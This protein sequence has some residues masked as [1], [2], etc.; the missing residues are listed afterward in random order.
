MAPQANLAPFL[1]RSS[2]PLHP[3]PPPFHHHL[4]F[5]TPAIHPCHLTPLP[6]A[7]C[8]LAICHSSPLPRAT[9]AITLPAIAIHHPLHIG[10]AISHLPKP[11]LLLCVNTPAMTCHSTVPLCPIATA[12]SYTEWRAPHWRHETC[13]DGTMPAL[14]LCHRQS[15]RG[16]A[17]ARALHLRDSGPHPTAW[18]SPALPNTTGPRFFS[19]AQAHVAW[20]VQSV[21]AATIIPLQSATSPNSGMAHQALSK[22][23]GMGR[24][25]QQTA[26][27][28][29]STGSSQG[30]V[31][32]QSTQSNTGAP[33]VERW[34]MEPKDALVQRRSDPLTPYSVKAWAEQL[35]ELD[36]Q[37]KYPL[38]VQGLLHSF[39][40]GIPHIE[41]TYI[42]PNHP[43]FKSLLNVYTSII[44]NEF[45]AG[46]YIGPFTCNQLEQAMGSFQTSPLSLVP[47]TS[48]PG[49]YRAVQIFSHL[50]DPT[51]R[52]TSVNSH[53]DCNDFP[54]TWG[55]F[56]TVALLISCLPPGLQASVCNVVDAYRTIPAAP[57]QWPGLVIRLQADDQFAVN[58]CNNFGFASAGGVYGMLADA[59]ADVFWG[60]GMGPLTKWVDDHM[61]FCL[62]RAHLSSYNTQQVEWHCK[63]QMHGACRQEGS[64]L[65][66]GGKALPSGS[67]EE[68]DE[69]CSAELCDLSGSSPC[70]AAD[71]VFAYA[72]ADIDKLSTHLGI[73]WQASKSV[74]FRT[75]FPYLGFWWDLHAQIVHLPDEKK[76]SYLAAITEWGKKHMHNLLEAQK[77]YRKLLHM[78]LV[79]PAGC[80]HLT[81][82]DVMTLQGQTVARRVPAVICGTRGQG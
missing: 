76:A 16:G 64:R 35:A 67:T 3:L 12:A 26:F 24:W 66:Y 33:A 50:H 23:I 55:T 58:V 1:S 65:W 13:P 78:A 6:F 7:I 68:F 45:T 25:S 71:Q 72:D 59:G 39:N 4:P 60:Q 31:Y 61:F 22:K 47:K 5:V 79:I 41:D 20:S 18:T 34:A 70:P 54:C 81:S 77:L 56:S 27:C 63:I 19:P 10:P 37:E 29:V 36:L 21:L 11:P 82:L 44:D 49:R 42:P 51:P 52:A 40:L 48:K 53:I 9:P 30:D 69:D 2:P 62:P 75:E 57:S 46:H 38:L 14:S 32:P 73:K 80:A 74:P 8:N 43:S 28:S 17:V 15:P